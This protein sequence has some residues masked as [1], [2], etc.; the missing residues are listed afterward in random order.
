MNACTKLKLVVLLQRSVTGGFGVFGGKVLLV[1]SGEVLQGGILGLG[2]EE[3]REDTGLC[4]ISNGTFGGD[5]KSLTNMNKAKISRMCFKK[6][7]FP[8]MFTNRLKPT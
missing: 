5:L 3:S 1:L 8:P 7:F 2:K 6:W 4:Y